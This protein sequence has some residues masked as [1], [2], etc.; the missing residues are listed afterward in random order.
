MRTMLQIKTLYHN[1][2]HDAYILNNCVAIR[3]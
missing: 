1:W 3:L 2:V